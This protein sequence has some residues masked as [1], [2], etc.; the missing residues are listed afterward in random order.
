MS[1]PRLLDLFCGAGGA[2][3]G[4]VRAGFEVVGVDIKPQP[5]YPFEFIR[6]HAIDY[7]DN[8]TANGKAQSFVAIHASPPCQRWSTQT[9]E[10]WN[11]HP[12]L[13][14]PVQRRLRQ[15]GL[16]YVIEN[17]PQAPLLDPVRLCGS[18][19]G[20]GVR[21]HRHFETNWKLTVPGCDHASQPPKYR[22]YDHGKWYIARTVPVY[23]T[24]GGKAKEHWADAMGIDWMTHAE[25]AE[26][27]P[28]AFTEFIGA[29]LQQHL[30][31][32]VAA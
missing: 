21:R 14:E 24:G 16:P 8:I 28:P 31:S 9:Q 25:M 30:E 3:M 23:G 2:G 29:Q 15:L 5:N 12:D 26:A 22:V 10:N 7:L 6:A 11:R 32:R 27:I 20:L 1:K 13:V 19:F 17:V 4:Y 18:A